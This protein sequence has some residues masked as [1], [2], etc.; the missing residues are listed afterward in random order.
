MVNFGSKKKRKEENVYRHLK[1]A[2]LVA[3]NLMSD[4]LT[5]FRPE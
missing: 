1:G 2:Y 5:V 3:A 4:S